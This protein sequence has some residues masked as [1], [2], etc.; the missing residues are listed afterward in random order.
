MKK[1]RPPVLTK[2]GETVYFLSARTYGGIFHLNGEKKKNLFEKILF[3]KAQKFLG[4]IKHWVV[5]S[6]H[7]HLLI[8]FL[9]GNVL[10]KFVKELHGSSSFQ[11]KRLPQ[12]EFLNEEQVA[13]RELTP[14]EQRTKLKI[15]DLWR[16]LKLARTDGRRLKSARTD[17]R[18]LKSARTETD[19]LADG[20]PRLKEVDSHFIELIK[21]SVES[22]NY[23]LFEV[24]VSSTMPEIPFWHNC[25]NHLI[26]DEAD[27]F[28]HFNYITQNPIKHGV[29]KNLWDYEFS[30]VFDYPK[31]YIIDCLRQYPIIDFGGEYA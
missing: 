30:G 27:Y 18:R 10:S 13:I 22:A 8:S 5:L 26:R 11:I 16:E 14:L 23:P 4:E 9:D 28:R 25:Y 24:L 29:V 20:R 7:Y 21:Q 15:G 12:I 31:D 19:V 1:H 3:D 2:E 17:G 6:N